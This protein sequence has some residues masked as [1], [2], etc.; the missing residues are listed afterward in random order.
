M[1]PTHRARAHSNATHVEE[2]RVWREAKAQVLALDV[3]KELLGAHAGRHGD[4]QVDL[5]ERLVPLV[6]RAPLVRELVALRG[7]QLVRHCCLGRAR[8][9]AR[10]AGARGEG[11][12]AR[13]C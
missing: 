12:S 13:D 9:A 4:V 3:A 10:P 2:G 7:R 1:T 5:D 6:H 11:Q 8:K